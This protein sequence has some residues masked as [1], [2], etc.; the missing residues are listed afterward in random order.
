MHRE[1]TLSCTVLVFESSL[2][3]NTTLDRCKYYKIAGVIY[4][5]DANCPITSGAENE[6]NIG[7]M[8]DIV[9]KDCYTQIV[10]NEH[11][12]RN[13]DTETALVRSWQ[14]IRIKTGKEMLRLGNISASPFTRNIVQE[15]LLEGQPRLLALQEEL[16]RK[17]LLRK[18]KAGTTIS[19]QI[20]QT[21]KNMEADLKALRKER[22]SVSKNPRRSD[23]DALRRLTERIQAVSD[24][25]E[26]L[27]R[28]QKLWKIL[29]I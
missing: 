28:E 23:P 5:Q 1:Q 9:G 26:E 19:S 29:E 16:Q 7:V 4:L 8:A 24:G 3:T 12:E 10:L 25:L 20:K 2:T 18:T 6:Y 27:K 22:N 21:I 13:R 14:R 11:N 17:P 15:L